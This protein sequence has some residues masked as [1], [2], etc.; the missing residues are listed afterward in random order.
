MNIEEF[1]WPAGRNEAQSAFIIF[2]V[3]RV[4]SFND[5]NAGIYFAVSKIMS[6]F[7]KFLY[8]NET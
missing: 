3:E 7:A 4:L 2:I 1:L 8:H 5:K 6:N